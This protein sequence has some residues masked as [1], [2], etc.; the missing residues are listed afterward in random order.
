MKNPLRSDPAVPGCRSENLA[1]IR[2]MLPDLDSDSMDRTKAFVGGCLTR[3]RREARTHGPTDGNAMVAADNAQR[4]V[5][6]QQKAARRK[7]WAW[8]CR[9]PAGKR[10]LCFWMS[11]RRRIVANDEG[12]W[13]AKDGLGD[14]WLTMNCSGL[15][16]AA[17]VRGYFHYHGPLPAPGKAIRVQIEVSQ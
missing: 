17:T 5:A 13:S 7:R 3:Q 1:A 15:F 11:G 4:C 12:W 6:A 8:L 14:D 16:S 9:E 2:K 10:S